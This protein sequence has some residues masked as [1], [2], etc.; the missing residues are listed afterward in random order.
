[1]W[2]EAVGAEFGLT[3]GAEENHVNLVWL[4]CNPVKI[5]AERLSDTKQECYCLRQLAG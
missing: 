5:G 2:K 1:M 4:I 3:K